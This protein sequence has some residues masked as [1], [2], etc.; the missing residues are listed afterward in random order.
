MPR[1][2]CALLR[3]GMPLALTLQRSAATGDQ[4]H[5]AASRA[6]FDQTYRRLVEIRSLLGMVQ[7]ET[8]V[9]AVLSKPVVQHEFAPHGQI[10]LLPIEDLKG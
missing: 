9:H 1:S 6:S 5:L 7:A 8:C 4:S 10:F 3:Q 2:S